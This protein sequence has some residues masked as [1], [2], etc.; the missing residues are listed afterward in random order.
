[1][2]REIGG[3]GQAKLRDASVALIGAGGLGGPAAL[4]LAAAGLGNITLIDPDIVEDSNLQR[5]IQFSETDI[6]QPKTQSLSARLRHVDKTLAVTCFRQSLDTDNA[7]DLL[8]G[9]DLI[10]DGTDN[11]QTR[12]TVN[13]TSRAHRIPLISGAV[14]GWAGQLSVFNLGSASP[15]YRCLV[16]DT[17]PDAM[18]CETV[19]IVGAVAGI[20]GSAMA[21]EAIKLI[22]G[23][24]DALSGRLWLYDGLTAQA[25]TV[26]LPR[27]P[28]CPECS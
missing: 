26:T 22:T 14:A 1:M 9:H 18:D 13:A 20:I 28:A 7:H 5:Q 11:F 23:A 4:Y 17:P 21:M 25:R 6:D 10:L 2:L 8:Q 16:P 3:A 19:G 27:D 12:F 24:G 15:C